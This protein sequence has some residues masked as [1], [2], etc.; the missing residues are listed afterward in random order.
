MNKLKRVYPQKNQIHPFLQY[1]GHVEYS[2]KRKETD[3]LV[4]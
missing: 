4:Y 1:Q 3:K 2:V